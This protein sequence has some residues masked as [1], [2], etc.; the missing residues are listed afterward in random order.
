MPD[1]NELRSRLAAVNG[2]FITVSLNELRVAVGAKRLGRYVLEEIVEWRGHEKLGF[3]PYAV[4]ANNE[5]P[6]QTQEVKALL[7]R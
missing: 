4:L 7:R 3:F 2:G 5:E 6:S 1:A